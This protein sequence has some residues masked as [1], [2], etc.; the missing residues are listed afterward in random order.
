[1]PGLRLN[2]ILAERQAAADTSKDGEIA[3]V[4]APTILLVVFTLDDQ[5]F[6]LPG[7][8]V[9]EILA[10][11]PLY[12]VPGAPAALEGVISVRGEIT[13]VLCARTLLGL[14]TAAAAPP[15]AVLLT[16]DEPLHSGLKVDDVSDLRELPESA[17]QPAPDSL[18]DHL[19][20]FVRALVRI[21]QRGVS[22]LDLERLFAAYLEH[23]V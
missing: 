5:A 11:P 20:P 16:R 21:G 10:A 1:M 12:R 8:Q 6:A 18:P 15:G 9:R 13:S 17:L 22:L 14:P 19:R 4:D 2:D 3:A 7:S 23:A